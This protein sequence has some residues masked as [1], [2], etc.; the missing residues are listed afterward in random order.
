MC[1]KQTLYV[2]NK[3][4]KCFICNKQTYGVLPSRNEGS[5]EV[6]SWLTCDLLTIFHE[7]TCVNKFVREAQTSL[8]H[9]LL[10][11]SIRT[12]S[13]ASLSRV[14][15]RNLA[16]AGSRN[17]PRAPVLGTTN[18]PVQVPPTS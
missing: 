14:G 3:Y 8:H 13:H 1:N 10:T 4:V 12:S 9:E 7:L 6:I 11:S 5:S 17:H 16:R 2:I 18:E 15:P